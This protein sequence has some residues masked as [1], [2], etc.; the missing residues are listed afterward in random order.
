[1]SNTDN[2]TSQEQTTEVGSFQNGVFIPAGEPTA[3]IP[4]EFERE[5]EIVDG[6][7]FWSWYDNHENAAWRNRAPGD[8][9]SEKVLEEYRFIEDLML[10]NMS[11]N[12]IREALMDVWKNEEGVEDMCLEHQISSESCFGI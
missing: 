2:W 8:M 10:T 9:S 5:T 3:P 1:M 11:W 4:R 7:Q 12:E 6:D